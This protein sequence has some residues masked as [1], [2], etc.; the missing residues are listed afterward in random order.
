M[1]TER[2]CTVTAKGQTTIPKA[3]R[4]ALGIGHGDRI[5]FRV[6]NG[7]VSL[8]ACVASDPALAPFLS[9]LAN[10]IAA[11]PDAL[12]PIDDRLVRRMTKAT[13]GLDVDPDAPIEGDV[14]L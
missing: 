8:H 7:A 3:M 1:R 10:D 4:H 9:L 13:E 2:I 11:R 14:A 12:R 6:G 5:A